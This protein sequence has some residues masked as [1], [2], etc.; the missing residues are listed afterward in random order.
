MPATIAPTKSE[1]LDIDA[2]R[3]DAES[4]LERLDDEC[5]HMAPEALVSIDVRVELED[6]ESQ[7]RAA[8]Q[9]LDR[10]ERADDEQE[11]RKR[12]AQEAA[13]SKRRD[14]ARERA[15]KA[16][17]RRLPAAAKVDECAGAYARALAAF[18][19]A[20]AEHER[21]LLDAGETGGPNHPSSLPA[22]RPDRIII[23][24]ALRYHLQVA[25]VEALLARCEWHADHVHPLTDSESK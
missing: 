21:H 20:C 6:R 3:T 23:E 9:F 2:L 12:E 1:D 4:L 19:T 25:G 5:R 8:E 11:R 14:A 13:E 17:A 24:S 18:A 7:K 16:A 15:S 22:L 10:L